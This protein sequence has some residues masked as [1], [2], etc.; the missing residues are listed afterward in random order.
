LS[1][2]IKQTGF[3]LVICGSE[4]TD[5]RT[6]VVPAMLAEHLGVAQLTLAS[7]VDIAGSE[8]TVRRVTDDG[9]AVVTASLTAVVS[10]VAKINEPRYPSFKGIMAAKK[11]PVQVPTLA[12]A[13]IEAAAVGLGNAA[14]A[15]AD[16]AALLTAARRLGEP[17][18]VWTGPGSAA[19]AARLAEYGT[20]KVCVADSAD[21]AG[22]LV[23][24]TAELLARLVA[25]TSPAAVLVAGTAEG[26]EI[27]GRLAVKTGS[28]V[29]TD[30]VDV[31]A[32]PAGAPVAEQANFGGAI[33]VHASV[34]KGTP[35]IA[36]RPNAV[37]AE[38]STGAAAP[39]HVAFAASDTARAMTI[40]ER[41]LAEPRGAAGPDRGADRGLRQ[42][43]HRVGRR[44]QGHRD[45]RRLPGRRRGRLARSPTSAGTPTSS[46]SGRP[47]RP[48]P[49]CTS[50]LA[51]PAPS[52]AG[53]TCRPPRRSSR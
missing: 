44:L 53:L 6:G 12:D 46:R 19:G 33:T 10:V 18:A 34:A 49:S 28:G 32:D 1:A 21:F 5:A 17:S 36:V 27:A 25:D 37:A 51:S 9:Y 40:T 22:Y 13:G 38:P 39:E 26:K 15:V 23:A 2:L 42:P 47:A 52:S 4:A 3:D 11:K 45:P 31:I 14:A 48:S 50:R 16:F 24:P 20:Q 8:V 41:I 35:I 43:R 29:L 30:A 7:K